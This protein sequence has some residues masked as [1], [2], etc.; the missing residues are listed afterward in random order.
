MHISEGICSPPVL[1]AGLGLAVAGVAYGLRKIDT[2]SIPRVGVLSSAFFVAS[3]IHVP[4]GPTSV[5]LVLNGL[6]GLL[7]GWAAFPAI[8]IA[9]L[10]QGVLFQFGGLTTLGVNT[11]NMALPAVVCHYLFRGMIRA[12]GMKPVALAGFACGFVSLTLSI[13]AVAMTL[14]LTEKAFLVTARVVL[15]AHVPVMVIEGLV[16]AFV[17]IFLKKVKPEMVGV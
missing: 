2:E 14:V 16:T 6:M 9:L 3:L 12:E 13:V 7:L 1:A 10:L 8:M 11:V 5:H 17:V 15:A 4:I